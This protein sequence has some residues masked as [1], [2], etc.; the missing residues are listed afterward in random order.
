MVAS[1]VVKLVMRAAVIPLL[2]AMAAC[3]GEAEPVAEPALDDIPVLVDMTNASMPMDAYGLSKEYGQLQSR[4][5]HLLIA[6]CMQRFGLDFDMPDFADDWASGPGAL[7]RQYGIWDAESAALYGYKTP[8]G[9]G[10]GGEA[11]SQVWTDDEELVLY[12]SDDPSATYAGE[13]IPTGGCGV[14]ANE[15]LLEG[16]PSQARQN[17]DL[18]LPQQLSGKAY[19]LMES[20]SRV[21]DVWAQWSG[22]MSEAGYDYADWREPNEDPQ[23]HTE[24]AGEVEIATAVADVECK[25]AVNQLGVMY[26]VNVAYEERLIDENAEALSEVAAW[27]AESAERYEDI[28]AGG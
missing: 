16:A 26:A 25:H 14:E 24:V 7:S 28:V 17:N 11:E 18:D 2:L 23:F 3:S 8:P 4:A 9:I 13:R 10:D 1:S 6:D 20:D 19:F 12:G 22:C 15:R 27:I 5:R 21:I